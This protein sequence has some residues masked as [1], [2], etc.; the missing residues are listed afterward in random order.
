MLGI[1]WL[2][3]ELS[4]FQEVLC[5]MELVPDT[6][7]LTSSEMPFPPLIWHVRQFTEQTAYPIYRAADPNW[8]QAPLSN[9]PTNFLL[10]PFPSTM[11]M[12][13]TGSS[14][15]LV[16]TYKTIR[17]HV[18]QISRVPGSSLRFCLQKCCIGSLFYLTTVVRL[19]QSL[20]RHACGRSAEWAKLIR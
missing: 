14:K 12:V 15:T 20:F 10:P 8:S 16:P 3:E 19:F 17:R 9:T 7:R 18:L 5:S 13:T 2:A 11:N 6:K 1:S 4:V